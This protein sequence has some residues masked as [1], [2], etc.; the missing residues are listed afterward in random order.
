MIGF[1][2]LV[3]AGKKDE[4]AGVHMVGLRAGELLGELSLAMHH[5]LTLNDILA[6]IHAYP[7]MNTGVQQAVFQAY[8]EGEATAKNRKFV[9]TILNFRR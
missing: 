5:H 3:L 6:T 9:R 2:K 4:I 1:I 7:T 8:F